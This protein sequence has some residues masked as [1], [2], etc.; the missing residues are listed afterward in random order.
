MKNQYDVTVEEL[1][2]Q[3]YSD[4]KGTWRPGTLRRTITKGGGLS[5]SLT[6]YFTAN[7][8]VLAKA[9]DYEVVGFVYV[10]ANPNI[11]QLK[12]NIKSAVGYIPEPSTVERIF[13]YITAL[14]RA[15]QKEDEYYA[16]QDKEEA[17]KVLE[18]LEETCIKR[19]QDGQMQDN[20]RFARNYPIYQLYLTKDEQ[21]QAAEAQKILNESAYETLYCSTSH[22][23]HLYQFNRKIQ[24]R[25]IEWERKEEQRKKQELEKKLLEQLEVNVELRRVVSLMLDTQKEI[26]TSDFEI[27]LTHRLFGYTSNFDDYRKHVPKRIQLLEGFGINSNSARTLLYLGQKYIDQ[28]GILPPAK[29]EYERDCDRMYYG[30]T[31]HDGFNNI[32]I[33]KIGHKY[34]YS[35]YSWKGLRANY[36]Q[37]NYIKPVKDPNMLYEYIYNECCRLNNCKFIPDA[38]FLSLEAVIERIHQKCKSSSRMLNRYEERISKESDPLAKEMLIKFKDGFE[39]LVLKEQMENLKAIPSKHAAEALKEAEKRYNQIQASHG[40]EFRSLAS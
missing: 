37:Y 11:N 27:E 4:R 14:Q 13:S 38:P 7:V 15:Y 36:R 18:R 30:D 39:C 10:F 16:A 20:P 17:Q 34:I 23:G 1:G 2:L 9:K 19:I 29:S 26:R 31:V 8:E 12:S 28:G 6:L 40:F 24:T 32:K 22:E 3:V 21:V 5:Y 35:D 25:S 33:G